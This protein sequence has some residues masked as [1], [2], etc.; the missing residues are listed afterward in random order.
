MVWALHHIKPLHINPTRVDKPVGH[1]YSDA[2]LEDVQGLNEKLKRGQLDNLHD[3][4]MSIGAYINLPQ[5]ARFFRLK[6]NSLPRFLSGEYMHIGILEALAVNVSTFIWAHL[7][8][9]YFLIQ[10]VDNLGD[11][12]ALCANSTR[13]PRTQKLSASIHQKIQD[14]NLDIYFTWICSARNLS[15]PLTREERF[16]AFTDFFSLA[17]EEQLHADFIIQNPHLWGVAR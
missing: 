4:K 1:A 8:R 12:F 9:D 17:T 15:D 6:L 7:L 2:A 11:V 13:C 14:Y 10:H 5:G 3:H 16:R